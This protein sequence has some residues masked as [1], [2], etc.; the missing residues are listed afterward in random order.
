MA[1]CSCSRNISNFYSRRFLESTIYNRNSRS[2]CVY[3]DDYYRNN[4]HSRRR[5]SNRSTYCENPYRR[6]RNSRNDC[7][8]YIR[9]YDYDDYI[10]DYDYDYDSYVRDYDDDCDDYLRGDYEDYDVYIIDNDYNYTRNTRNCN[11]RNRN[12]RNC[13]CNHCRHEN[14]F[15]LT[16]ENVSETGSP[17]FGSTFSLSLEGQVVS[18]ESTNVRGIA[19]FSL[20][21]NRNYQLVQTKAGNGFCIDPAIYNVSVDCHGNLYIN[22]ILRCNLLIVNEEAYEA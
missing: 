6:S 7:Y 4:Q 15:R 22:G 9:D 18:I 5:R 21:P 13:S 10:R 17:I 19:C 12:N 8:N 11:N 14:S 1:N 20:M 3:D 2:E 16:V